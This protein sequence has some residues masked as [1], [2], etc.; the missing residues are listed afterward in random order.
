MQ[1][2][3]HL[4]SLE[5]LQ[6][7]DYSVFY[8]EFKK[9]IEKKI[10]VF[11][12]L[13]FVH[14][15][16]Q[17]AQKLIS[18]AVVEKI[19]NFFVTEGED[20]SFYCVIDNHIILSLPG[21]Y[22]RIVA[23]LTEVDSYLAKKVSLDWLKELTEE[24][25]E[26][27]LL[28][29]KAGTNLATG[30]YNDKQFYA[31]LVHLKDHGKGAVMLIE[32][33]PQAKTAIEAKLHTAKAARILSEYL[34]GQLP[35]F[36]LGNHLFAIIS[37]HSQP[38]QF[39]DF[40]QKLFLV[41]RKE[42]FRKVHIGLDCPRLEEA[43][44]DIIAE[45][46][47]VADNAFK[48]LQTANK[49]GPFSLCDFEH[50][51][52]PEKHPLRRP[53]RSLMG[54][55]STK[56]RDIDTFSLVQFETN[57]SNDY[58]RLNDIFAQEKLIVDREDH[59]VLLPGT[60]PERALQYVTEKI[61]AAGVQ[62]IR[63]GVGYYPHS[64]FTKSNVA[65][66][67]RKALQHASFFGP[68]GT[69][70]IDEVSFNVSGDI[71]Y[72]EGDIRSAIKEYRI[73]LQCDKDNINLLNSLGVAYTDI[74]QH[75]RA[76]DYFTRVLELDP[77]NFMALYNSGLGA[78]Q[79]GD[80]STAL[81][82]F[83]RASAVNSEHPEVRDDLDFHLGKLYTVT[84]KYEKA[85]TTL[86]NLQE[87]GKDLKLKGRALTYLGRSYYGCAQ[88]KEAMVWLQR[89]LQ[90]NEFD[91][92]S[93]GLLGIVYQE[94]GEGNEIALSLCQKAV[95]LD[96]NSKLLQFYLAKALY[97]VGDC[98]SARATLRKCLHVKSLRIDAK[99]LMSQCY[100]K[101]KLPRRAAYWLDKLASGDSLEK[102]VMDKV[103][104]LQEVLNEI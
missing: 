103:T 39:R 30:L 94:N 79:K 9:V 24:I 69:A 35:L 34:E 32:L 28:I 38:G 4:A 48:A 1:S 49:R 73:G 33:F 99:L 37:G 23:V 15:A 98:E 95:E 42:G 55:L 6:A 62:N 81:R 77:N 12:N 11:N 44:G 29:K 92:D 89:A 100:L 84:G 90:Y 20:Q 47:D 18:L 51:R 76:K 41:L 31:T 71:Y 54:R 21:K 52:Y 45:P 88:I 96:S 56:W 59:F 104:T 53:T 75:H 60:E 27:F 93:M 3:I 63:I 97:A 101:Q 80:F 10:P 66:N 83:E 102:S 43:D 61:T 86:E 78:E 14:N 87:T 17:A 22:D 64:T 5:Y 65:L 25:V 85:I 36:Y 8:Q 2:Y 46:Y 58:H 70:V 82:Y 7:R 13:I 67:C 91:A 19:S 40:S 16:E 50:L 26:Q 74:A 68:A 72:A 57:E